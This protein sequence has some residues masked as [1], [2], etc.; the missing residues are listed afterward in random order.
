MIIK[1]MLLSVL[2][3]EHHVVINGLYSDILVVINVI[4]FLDFVVGFG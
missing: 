2:Y 1:K 4:N 3:V